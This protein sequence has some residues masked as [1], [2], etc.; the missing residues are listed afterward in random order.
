MPGIPAWL[1]EWFSMNRKNPVWISEWLSRP[2]ADVYGPFSHAGEGLGELVH[3]SRAGW[4]Q[5]DTG[6]L[7]ADR[8]YFSYF[9]WTV[10]AMRINKVA[11]NLTAAGVGAQ[12]A[13]IGLFSSPAPGG[14]WSSVELSPLIATGNMADLA[15][16]AGTALKANADDFEFVVPART[17]LWAG[18]RT[19]MAVTQPSCY[20]KRDGD[21]W[22]CQWSDAAGPLTGAGPWPG[23]DGAA[24]IHP[25]IYIVEA[26]V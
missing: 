5:V 8:A 26:S 6:E 17:H 12:T 3:Y 21:A 14:Q 16:V 2:L 10:R 1:K 24:T 19:N 25:S 4:G 22:F 11:V 7:V 18:I 23:A 9:G 13:E 20:G 15:S